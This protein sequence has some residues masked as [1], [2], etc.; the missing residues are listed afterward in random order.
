MRSLDIDELP[1][2]DALQDNIML[3]RPG[4]DGK[5]NILTLTLER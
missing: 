2:C 3:R 4:D 5:E 1:T